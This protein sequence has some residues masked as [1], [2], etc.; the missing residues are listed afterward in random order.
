MGIIDYTSRLAADVLKTTY[1]RELGLSESRIYFRLVWG[2]VALGG[3]HPA[4]GLRPAAACCSSSRR[5]SGGAM[6]FLYSLL[7]HPAEPPGAAAGD[8]VRLYRLAALVW[9]TVFFGVLSV[10]DDL[11][12]ASELAQA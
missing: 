4:A 12:A 1:L 8:P 11:A 2:M 3:D 9:S 10:A 7:L 6:M 5:A